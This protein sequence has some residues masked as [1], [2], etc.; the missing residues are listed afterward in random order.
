MSQSG[1][2]GSSQQP[3]FLP[4]QYPG[5]PWG[6]PRPGWRPVARP[7][8]QIPVQYPGVIRPIPV[9]YP[10]PRGP[11]PAAYPVPRQAQYPLYPLYPA[12]YGQ[13]GV[14]A[15]P[16]YPGYPRYQ[17]SPW[18]V[19]GVGQRPKKSGLPIV[20]IIVAVFVVV[21]PLI[22]AILSY[23]SEPTPEPTPPA[24]TP[25]APPPAPT[26]APQT[27][28]VSKPTS[29]PTSTG[30]LPTAQPTP[31]PE[32]TPEETPEPTPSSTPT[33]SDQYTPG[34]PDLNPNSAPRPQTDAERDAALYSNPL[35]P[36]SLSPTDCQIT[37]MDFV[38]APAADIEAYLNDYM[39]CLMAAWYAPVI[40]AGFSLPHP[41]VIVYTQEVNTPC[42]YMPWS[43]AAYCT[44]NQQI[45]YAQD[46]IRQFPARVQTM[47]FSVEA[48][49]AHE[50][51]HHVQYR[52]QITMSEVFRANQA[53]SE[54]EALDWSRRLEIQA[55]CFA[56]SFL[57]SVAASTN[58][59]AS[60]E[61]NLTY[62]FS[63]G[64]PTP[65]SD[66]HGTGVS[67]EYWFNQGFHNWN[68]GACNTFTASPDQVS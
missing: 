54:A 22:S 16:P 25:V 50:F 37:G 15:P 27:T 51:G 19:P 13:P 68:V 36:Q 42:G 24:Y 62:L 40:H 30:Q 5:Y 67:R 3:T 52:T 48:I 57:N 39:N 49:V 26:F 14:P 60:D 43:G 47:R 9:Q 61:D 18:P 6:V 64:S 2:W 35:Y 32:V 8:G 45:Y 21:G 55:D 66:D 7:Y 56:G 23:E 12:A 59:T 4:P 28:S 29:K 20:I 63:M 10:Y 31:T 46:F 34:P 65:Y 44:G 17:Q 11:Y 53:D 1:P 58:L 33:P 38:N 41:S